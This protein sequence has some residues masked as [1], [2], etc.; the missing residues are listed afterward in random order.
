MAKKVGLLIYNHKRFGHLQD[1]G[2]HKKM[3]VVPCYISTLELNNDIKYH[4]K[5]KFT[6][7]FTA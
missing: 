5:D 6:D 3:A 4:I 7:K 2:S 1:L